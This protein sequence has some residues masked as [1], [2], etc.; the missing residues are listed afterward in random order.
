MIKMMVVMTVKMVTGDSEY[1]GMMEVVTTL[2][3]T[4]MVSVVMMK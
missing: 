3:K 4:V 2:T 1:G